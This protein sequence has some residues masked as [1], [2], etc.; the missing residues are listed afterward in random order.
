LRVIYYNVQPLQLFTCW[1]CISGWGRS[2]QC[3]YPTDTRYTQCFSSL[4]VVLII[5]WCFY[6]SVTCV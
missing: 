4:T 1:V 3:L 6:V 2:I 5:T